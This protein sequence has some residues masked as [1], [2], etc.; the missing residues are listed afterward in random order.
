MFHTGWQSQ[1]PQCP[2]LQTETGK[3]RITVDMVNTAQ[4]QPDYVQDQVPNSNLYSKFSCR[5]VYNS[6]VKQSIAAMNL[7]HKNIHGLDD[8][9]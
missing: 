2:G 7:Q 8:M 9:V 5:C 6:S 4:L 3:K 1:C